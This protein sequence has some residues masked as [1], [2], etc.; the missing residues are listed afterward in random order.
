[1][2]RA[3]FYIGQPVAQSDIYNHREGYIAGFD[4]DV[5]WPTVSVVFPEEGAL[6]EVSE[7]TAVDWADKATHKAKS[8][9]DTAEMVDAAKAATAKRYDARRAERAERI[10]AERAFKAKLAELAGANKGVV[11]AEYRVDDSDSQSDYWGHK[12]AGRV[13]LGFTKTDRN[14]FGNMRKHAATWENTAHLAT[15]PK[16]AEHRENWSMGGGY[17]LKD[18]SRHGTGW[19]V[20]IESM[21]WVGLAE[22]APATGGYVP[23]SLH[24]PADLVDPIDRPTPGEK[25]RDELNARDFPEDEGPKL[26]PAFLP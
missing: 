13:I 3:I 25:L 26:I 24:G 16:S 20:S 22:F 21:E 11:V 2:T 15:A 4:G 19:Y 1:M 17:Y 6:T 5:E 10:V 9:G 8:P 23:G 7:S 18:G 14:H 12:T